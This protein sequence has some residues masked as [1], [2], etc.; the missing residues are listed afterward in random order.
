MPA[1]AIYT[2]GHSTRTEEEFLT[3]LQAHGIKRI[4]DVRS[5]PVS[6]HN[7][8]FEGRHLQGFLEK[9][10]IGYEHLGRLGGLRTARKDSLNTGWKNRSFRGYADHMETEEFQA[11]LKEATAIAEREPCAL[12]CAEAVPWRCHRFLLSDAFTANGWEV[13]HIMTNKK[14]ETHRPTPFLRIK[15]GRIIYPKGGE[16]GLPF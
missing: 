1:G 2:V 10:G 12:M 13:R 5:V 14:W 3:L 6:T 16:Q 9:N 11:G 8:H 7:P 4:L 15:D